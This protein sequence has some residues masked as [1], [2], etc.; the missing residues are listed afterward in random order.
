MAQA[1]GRERPGPA[2]AI[3]RYRELDE[4]VRGERK[5]G[6]AAADSSAQGQRMLRPAA[7]RAIFLDECV[8]HW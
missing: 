8:E 5:C 7:L 6:W 2:L 3:G 4:A 1:G